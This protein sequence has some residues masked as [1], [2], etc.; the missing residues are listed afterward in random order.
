MRTLVAMRPAADA[1][2]APR[3]TTAPGHCMASADERLD[4]AAL[5]RRYGDMVYGRCLSMLRNEADAIDA[6]QEVFLKV[7]RYADGFR[8]GAKASTWL[9]RIATNQCLNV[10]RSRRRHPEDPVEEIQDHAPPAVGDDAL[11]ALSRH[12]LVARLLQDWDERTQQCVVYHYMD[13]M[14]QDEVGELLGISGAA[15][16]KRL[17]KFRVETQAR[18]PDWAGWAAVP[19]E[20]R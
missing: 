16:R 18:F 17:A 2:A 13:G 15:V 20:G 5:Y 10:M 6:T 19:S 4:V 3:S 8:G 12:Q 7:H 11:D 1:I 14:T 9:Y